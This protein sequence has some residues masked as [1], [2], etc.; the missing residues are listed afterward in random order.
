M[1]VMFQTLL[2]QLQPPKFLTWA[3]FRFRAFLFRGERMNTFKNG[4]NTLELK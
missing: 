2:L 1:W 4:E 3:V